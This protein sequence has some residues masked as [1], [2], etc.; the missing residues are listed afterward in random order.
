MA[1]QRR[2]Q[3]RLANPLFNPAFR[4]ALRLGIAPRAFALLE[5]RGRRS[6]RRRQTPVGNGL[7]GDV[8]CLV[9]E[10]GRK[11]DY[12]KNLGQDPRVRSKLAAGGIP[13]PQPS[14][15]RTTRTPAAASMRQ[16][17]SSAE[18]MASSFAPPPVHRS[19]C[20]STWPTRR[21]E[22]ARIEYGR[23][24]VN[25]VQSPNVLIHRRFRTVRIYIYRRTRCCTVI[26]DEL[27]VCTSL[28]SSGR[29]VPKRQLA[30]SA[31]G[32][33][34]EATYVA[35]SRRVRQHS[36]VVR[37]PGGDRLRAQLPKVGP[38][39]SHRQAFGRRDD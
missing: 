30:A 7:D 34:R 19:P 13:V 14:S 29:E 20:G 27:D 11:G 35:E 26:L 36:K 15:T 12:V 31:S 10:H 22:Y 23:L 3:H 2:L 38:P 37:S 8:F 39:Q 21:L 32:S 18:S 5:T 9:S 17:G 6:G 33:T 28:R 1:P 4:A 25:C 16:T 24:P